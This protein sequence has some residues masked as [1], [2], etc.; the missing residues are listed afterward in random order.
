[1]SPCSD[2][3]PLAV[4]VL[5]LTHDRA[6]R[7]DHLLWGLARGSR[8]PLEV[9]VIRMNELVDPNLS[10]TYPTLSIRQA[11]LHMT[12]RAGLPLAAAR[13]L[14][15]GM[16]HGAQLLFLDVDC[17][18]HQEWLDAMSLEIT[19]HDG[20]VMGAAAYLPR[21]E[22]D[23]AYREQDLDQ[24][25]ELHPRRPQ[26]EAYTA[27]EDYAL[28]LS[29]CFGCTPSTFDRIGGFDLAF[30][31]HGAE[32]T[33]FAFRARDAGVPLGFAPHKVYHQ[34][35]DVYRPPLNH[36][37]S[38]LDN[39][40]RFYQRWGMW[41]MIGWLEAFAS[42]GLIAW[43]QDAETLTRLRVPT[44]ERIKEALCQSGRRF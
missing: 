18:P 40:E 1:M 28:F 23:Q 30:R 6:D 10:A 3:A 7:L 43:H 35:H 37:E 32:D 34:Y 16:A 21:L 25:G 31:G 11:A 39:A 17:I 44:P 26:V 13:N 20:L 2:S 27:W 5:T 38:I 14:A 4:S 42:E 15:R 12:R 33:D 8:L 9:I 29:L 41:P 22:P 36:F 19:R 24:L